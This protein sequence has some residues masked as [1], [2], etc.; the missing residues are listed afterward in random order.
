[1]PEKSALDNLSSSELA[2]HLLCITEAMSIIYDVD[3]STSSNWSCA[4]AGYVANNLRTIPAHIARIMDDIAAKAVCNVNTAF[5]IRKAK[6]TYDKQSM[7]FATMTTEELQDRIL[8][9]RFDDI[10]LNAV[11]LKE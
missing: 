3:L 5:G 7:V 4:K 9:R 6:E 11:K 10:D 8:R 1:M 2:F